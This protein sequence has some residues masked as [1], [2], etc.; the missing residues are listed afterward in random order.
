VHEED[1]IVFPEEALP[2]L[3]AAGGEAKLVIALEKR[4]APPNALESHAKG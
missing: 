4:S 3:V 1:V 2:D